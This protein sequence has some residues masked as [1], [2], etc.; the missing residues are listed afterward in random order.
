MSM[1]LE[2]VE[3][4]LRLHE[5]WREVSEAVTA[6]IDRADAM[7]KLQAQPFG[8]T[9]VQAEH[10]MVCSFS[11]RTEFARSELAMERDALR[12]QLGW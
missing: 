6:S 1:R 7:G 9:E 8:F 5:Q 11:D 4:L 12:E 2:I 10:I 3:G